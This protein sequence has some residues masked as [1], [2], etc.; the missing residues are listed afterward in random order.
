M[1][2]YYDDTPGKNLTCVYSSLFDF[3]VG[4]FFG[5]GIT[6][7]PLSGT[8]NQE[9][10]EYGFV[11]KKI[12]VFYFLIFSIT[13]YSKYWEKETSVSPI[14]ELAPKEKEC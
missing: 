10:D 4:Y 2:L 3:S 5:L 9:W 8:K 6:R 12:C 1:I 14:E 11:C 13:Y 7:Y